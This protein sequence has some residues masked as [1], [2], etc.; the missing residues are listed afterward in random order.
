MNHRV[1]VA[2]VSLTVGFTLGA[3]APDTERA[4]QVL[5]VAPGGSI[6][7]VIQRAHTGDI[8]LVAAG[9]YHEAVKVSVD[10]ITIRGE[11]RNTVILD[12]Q[13]QL[14]NGIAVAA[15]E[16]AVE[17]LT[18]HSYT[19]NGVLFNGIDAA[20]GGKGAQQGV[21]YGTGEDVLKGFRVSYVTAYNNGL[22]GIYAFASRDGVIEQSYVSGHPDSGIYV[23][24]CK[25]CN[26]VV[27]HVT[28]ELNAIGYYGTNA[29]GGVYVIESVFAHNRL[30]I[31][32]NSQR[33]ERLSPQADTVVAG[34]LVIDNDDPTAPPIPNG[35]FGV[36][37]AVG[38]GTR[39][40]VVHNRVE[41]NDAAGIAVVALN[42]FLPLD[43]RVQAN[44]LADN[45]VDLVYAP[46][47]ATDDGGNCFVDNRFSTSLPD[48]IESVLSCTGGGLRGIPLFSMPAAPQG[49][50][51]RDTP[52]PAPQPS[53]PAAAMDPRGG[54]GSV[55]T[56]DLTTVVVPER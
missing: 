38:G 17:N 14:A 28:A 52:P 45:G 40:V 54:S 7:E 21:V 2:L 29:S 43:N 44:E 13:H 42:E 49:G 55:P 9:T 11:D 26:T 22:Y 6:N 5:H 1:V 50:D 27:R 4:A 36:G 46:A 20:T 31:A 48:D 16:V 24:Q 39:N 37:I 23:G 8:V 18:V 25:P 3:C 10:G 51:Y 56:V 19:Q 33:A 34:N 30:G 32:P 41:G 35:Y 15:D 12:G 53:M 47:G